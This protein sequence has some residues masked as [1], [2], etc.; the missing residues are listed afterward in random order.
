MN[1]L[2]IVLALVPA[3]S[4]QLFAI[5]NPGQTSRS[6]VGCPGYL[7]FAGRAA[8]GSAACGGAACCPCPGTGLPLIG[9]A[10][11]TF[12]LNACVPACC[13]TGIVGPTTGTVGTG[14]IPGIGSVVVPSGAGVVPT[15]G[16]GIL[17][18][19]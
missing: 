17:G 13:P 16:T 9:A 18:K 7:R 14:A 10:A 8:I 2:L 19:K 12:I 15:I 1:S 6:T 11:P 5:A 3:I 4:A